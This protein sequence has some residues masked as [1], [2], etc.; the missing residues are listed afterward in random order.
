MKFVYKVFSFALFSTL[1]LLSIYYCRQKQL[2]LVYNAIQKTG[3]S[4]MEEL[5]HDQSVQN[6]FTYF[7]NNYIFQSLKDH[8]RHFGKFEQLGFIKMVE[9]LPKPAVYV[10]EIHFLEVISE[11]SPHNQPVYFSMMRDPV[12]RFKSRYQWCRALETR[13]HECWV[14]FPS[15]DQSAVEGFVDIIDFRESSLND[16]IEKGRPSCNISIGAF[17]DH[18]IVSF[19]AY[20]STLLLKLELCIVV[21][22]LRST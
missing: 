20:R 17:V 16:C 10:Q 14:H 6:G 4:M 8:K 7:Q 2:T 19:T 12:D 22:S 18:Q 9:L 11:S 21:L 3:S 13:A 1:F 15:Y 5:I